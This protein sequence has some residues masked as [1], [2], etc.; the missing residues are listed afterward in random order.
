MIVPCPPDGYGTLNKPI[1]RIKGIPLVLDVACVILVPVEQFLVQAIFHLDEI[2]KGIFPRIHRARN[3]SMEGSGMHKRQNG[4]KKDPMENLGHVI[5]LEF[6]VT[7]KGIL[8][9][10]F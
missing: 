3:L 9:K 2:R 8:P 4:E 1:L 5:K 6:I 7:S 10:P